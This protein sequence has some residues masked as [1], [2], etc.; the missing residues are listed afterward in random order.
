LKD[1][2]AAAI[3]RKEEPKEEQQKKDEP[4]PA[5]AAH[6]PHH[7]HTPSLKEALGK[8][9][10]EHQKSPVQLPEQTL[11]DMLRVDEPGNEQS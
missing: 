9:T 1:A 3:G 8:I 5:P 11:R 4:T 10:G 7:Q 6:Q 2:L